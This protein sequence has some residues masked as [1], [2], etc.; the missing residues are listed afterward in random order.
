MK[1]WLKK[2]LSFPNSDS[3][4]DVKTKNITGEHTSNIVTWSLTA[5]SSSKSPEKMRERV[6]KNFM[7]ILILT[8]INK[9]FLASCDVIRP[10]HR[11]FSV[12]VSLDNVYSLSYL[13]ERGGQ[14]NNEKHIA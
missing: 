1:L 5:V 2:I 4:F 10:I 14:I 11:R 9:V 7:N 13:M 3:E 8:G 12:L 6:I